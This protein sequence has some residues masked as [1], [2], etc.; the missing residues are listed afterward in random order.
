[1]NCAVREVTDLFTSRNEYL[2]QPI[3]ELWAGG[4][5]AIGLLMNQEQEMGNKTRRGGSREQHGG[6]TACCYAETLE[7]GEKIKQPQGG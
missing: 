2:P 1:M 3:P 4:A 5:H 6:Q 7:I